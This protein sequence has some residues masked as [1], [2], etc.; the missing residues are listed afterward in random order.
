MCVCVC[1]CSREGF[2]FPCCIRGLCIFPGMY[3]ILSYGPMVI[4]VAYPNRYEN[5]C[6]FFLH[7]HLRSIL[8][9]FGLLLFLSFLRLTRSIAISSTG[10]TLSMPTSTSQLPVYQQD[11]A[12]GALNCRCP[13]WIRPQVPSFR[14]DSDSAPPTNACRVPPFAEIMPCFPTVC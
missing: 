8:I 7:T 4:Q 1:V 11:A 2:Y 12:T 14:L 5:P 6:F 10:S 3:I 9:G 13:D